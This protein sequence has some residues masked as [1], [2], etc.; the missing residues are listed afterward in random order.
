M[1]LVSVVTGGAGFIGSHIVDASLL[2]D[3]RFVFLT[4]SVAGIRSISSDIWRMI[5][6]RWFM[7]IFADW[8]QMMPFSKEWIMSF[9][10]LELE[11][12]FHQLSDRLTTWTSMFR[13]PFGCLRL[14]ERTGSGKWSTQHL[15]HVMDSQQPQPRRIT[16]S[17]LSTL[18]RCQNTLANRLFFTGP[19]CTNFQLIPFESLTHTD[20]A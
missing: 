2:V 7:A 18:T 12:L 16:Q 3:M 9:I 20:R 11:T 8:K 14:R 6:S 19:R 13:A 4:T 10:L 5:E 15:R 17:V 1:R